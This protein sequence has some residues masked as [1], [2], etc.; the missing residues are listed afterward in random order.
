MKRTVVSLQRRH[1]MIAGLA[2]VAAPATLFAAPTPSEASATLNAAPRSGELLLV[3]GRIVTRQGEPVHGATIETARGERVRATTD[4]D[5]RFM[6]LATTPGGGTLA[7]RITH[8]LHGSYEGNLQL[9]REETT[10]HVHAQCDEAG[11]WRA[12]F[13]VSL[14]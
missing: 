8:D 13:G 2:G 14:A 4:A 11:V 10:R 5:G 7:Y 12:T 9:A 3:S 1:L 6:L